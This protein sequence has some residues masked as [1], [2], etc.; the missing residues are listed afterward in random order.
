MNKQINQPML[1][2]QGTMYTLLVFS[3]LRYINCQ[4]KYF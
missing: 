4:K 2:T 3:I 1:Y